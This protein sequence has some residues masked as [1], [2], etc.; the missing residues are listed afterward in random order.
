[1]ASLKQQVIVTELCIVGTLTAR[2]ASTVLLNIE[3]TLSIV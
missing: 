3:T 1:M 2:L